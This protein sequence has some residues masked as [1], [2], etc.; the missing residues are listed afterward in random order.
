MAT[1]EVTNQARAL[2]GGNL[3][4][5]DRALV[6]ALA[7]YAP[8]APLDELERLGA[9]AGKPEVV[10][11]G[12]D[13]NANPPQL[14]T[15]DRAAC[16]AV[17]RRCIFPAPAPR[18]KILRLGASGIRARMSDLDDLRRA[19]NVANAARTLRHLGVPIGE[20]GLRAGAAPNRK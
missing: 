6:E 19:G 9:L 2:I 13:A 1:H 20:Q 18:G 15:H 4:S 14:H 17:A 3:F 12:F 11:L 5:G 7:A 8:G 10:A 16:D